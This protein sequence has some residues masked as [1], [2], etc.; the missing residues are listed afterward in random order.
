MGSTMSSRQLYCS[1]ATY[2]ALLYNS[3]KS[4]KASSDSRNRVG[5]FAVSGVSNHVLPSERYPRSSLIDWEDKRAVRCQAGSLI[6]PS[7]VLREEALL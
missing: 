6:A 5:T 4:I 2:R 1:H 3:L 7:H